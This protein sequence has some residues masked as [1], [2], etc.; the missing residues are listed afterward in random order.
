MTFVFRLISFFFF[1]RITT[2][3]D[4]HKG[5]MR[6]IIR[7]TSSIKKKRATSFY[8]AQINY[9][10]TSGSPRSAYFGQL[11]HVMRFDFYA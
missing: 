4:S 1:S 5:T 9:T 2:C 8:E 3:M 11:I 7:P 6:S 10:N